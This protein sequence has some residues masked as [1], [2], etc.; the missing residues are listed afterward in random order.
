M[1]MSTMSFAGARFVASAF[2]PD[3]EHPVIDA[4]L[5]RAE[6]HARPFLARLSDKDLAVL[7][8]APRQIAGIRADAGAAELVKL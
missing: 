8:F 4:R 1:I 2:A 7:G 6:A 5:R 3:S